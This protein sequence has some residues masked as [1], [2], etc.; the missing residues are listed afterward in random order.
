[1]RTAIQL[2]LLILLYTIQAAPALAQCPVAGY[3]ITQKASVQYAINKQS[4]TA[5]HDAMGRSYLYVAGKERGLVIYDI[6]N[7]AAPVQVDS[8]PTAMLNNME[9]MNL[10]QDGN[11]LYLALGNH[12]VNSS[13]PGM[14]IIDVTTPAAATVKD[15]WSWPTASGGAGIVAVQGNYAYLGAMRQGLMILDIA[16]KSNIGFVSQFVPAKN[17]PN[18]SFPD[19]LKYNARGME[20]KGNYVYLCYDAGGLRIIDITNKSAPAEI[21]KYSNT[22]LYNQHRAYNNIVLDDSI[23]YVALDYCGIEVLNVNHLLSISQVAWWNKW[24]CDTGSNP[25]L[26]W[27]NN[28]GHANEIR[29]NKACKLLFLSTGKSELQVVNISNPANP[30]LCDS[31]GNTTNNQGSWGVSLYMDK[32]II[33]YIYAVYIPIVTPFGSNWGGVKLLTWNNQCELSAD[34]PVMASAEPYIYPNPA[35]N[36]IA[37]A[38]I[39]AGDVIT[40]SDITGR[41]ISNNLSVDSYKKLDI[42]N[43]RY[44]IYIISINNKKHLRFI[45]F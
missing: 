9:V 26:N 20:V 4:M 29:L 18:P 15:V 40:L 24:Q 35:I 23:A 25:S 2:A 44:G 6:S 8:V 10:T 12:F 7:Y 34:A 42:N 3:S 13:T 33:T 11:Y 41:V 1:M 21:S 39:K 17:W 37:V 16:D 27:S 36:E 5:A 43:L 45:K 32:L 22:A 28:D 31:F 30:Q 19:S 38:N 14:A